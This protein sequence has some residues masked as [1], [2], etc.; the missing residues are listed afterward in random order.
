MKAIRVQPDDAAMA[1]EM[2]SLENVVIARLLHNDRT[3]LQVSSFHTFLDHLN[4][5]R[6]DLP[7]LDD[8]EVP[9]P[10]DATTF[11][12]FDEFSDAVERSDLEAARGM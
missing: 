1:D 10:R 7:S 9:D 4:S 12:P 2:L 6:A 5:L 11:V 3:A 8:V